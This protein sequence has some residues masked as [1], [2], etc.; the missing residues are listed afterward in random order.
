VGQ[1]GF[2]PSLV[3][4]LVVSAAATIVCLLVAIPAAYALARLRLRAGPSTPS[5][6]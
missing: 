1:H 5:F 2:G 4:S 3:A 6:S